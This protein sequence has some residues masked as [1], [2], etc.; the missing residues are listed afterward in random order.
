MLKETSLKGK[1]LKKTNNL[2]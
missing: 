1:I 2:F